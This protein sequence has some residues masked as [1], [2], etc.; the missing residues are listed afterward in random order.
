MEGLLQHTSKIDETGIYASTYVCGHYNT[1]NIQIKH[2]QH[3][4]EITETF[5]IHTCNM[6]LKHLKKKHLK[7][8]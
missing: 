4:F 1:C 8:T 6:L 7:N 2:L 5:E 3:M